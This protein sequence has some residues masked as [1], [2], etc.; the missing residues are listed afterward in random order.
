MDRQRSVFDTERH[1]G[2]FPISSG[3]SSLALGDRN[4]FIAR[5]PERI[6][7]ETFD[8]S[9]F[10]PDRR[11]YHPDQR[12]FAIGTYGNLG[13]LETFSRERRET[14]SANLIPADPLVNLL[15]FDEMR[16]LSEGFAAHFAPERLFTRVS[17]QMHLDVALVQESS[18]A[19]GTPVHRL[20]LAAYQPGLGSIG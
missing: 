8:S 6:V 12:Y 5:I 17:S 9:A 1:F 18:V 4:N 19:D 14:S 10:L 16:L 7:L 3:P 20:L 13:I 2:R 15:V 11:C